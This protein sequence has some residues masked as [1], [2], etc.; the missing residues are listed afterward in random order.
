MLQNHY[1]EERHLLKE[2]EFDILL[3]LNIAADYYIYLTN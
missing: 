3:F 2:C 1:K